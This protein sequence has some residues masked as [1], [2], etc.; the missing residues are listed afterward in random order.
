MRVYIILYSKNP[1]DDVC[2]SSI[3]ECYGNRETAIAELDRIKKQNEDDGYTYYLEDYFVQPAMITQMR[4][5][6]NVRK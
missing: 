3:L 5:N 2:D 4:D 1:R 6:E